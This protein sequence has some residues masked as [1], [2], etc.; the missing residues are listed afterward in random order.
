[1]FGVIEIV[2]FVLGV[3]IGFIVAGLSIFVLMQMG[4]AG[5]PY[6]SNFANILGNW[7]TAW[8]PIILLIGAASIVIA[9][10]IRRF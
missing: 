8:F 1:M 7:S 6:L 10:L 3:V 2:A 5:I 9:L 4:N